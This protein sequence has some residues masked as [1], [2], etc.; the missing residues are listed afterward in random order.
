[1]TRILNRSLAA[2]FFA[3]CMFSHYSPAAEEWKGDP[4]QTNLSFAAMAG[5]GVIGGTVGFGLTGAIAVKI[6]HEGFIPDIN[7]QVFLEFQGGPLF[8]APS[9]AAVY[10]LFMRW[11]FH[12]NDDFSLYSLGGVGGTVNPTRVYPRVALGMIYRL[13]GDLALRA[14]LSHEFIGAGIAIDFSL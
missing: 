3:F 13:S 10:G 1:M 4:L 14:E 7:D 11:D 9:A 8:L 5:A 2:T 6:A 12:K